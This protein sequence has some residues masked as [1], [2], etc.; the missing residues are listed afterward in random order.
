ML[1]NFVVNY[2]QPVPTGF[3]TEKPGPGPAP[4]PVL[5][6][7]SGSRSFKFLISGSG[8]KPGSE[9]FGPV[10]AQCSPLESSYGDMVFFFTW[11]YSHVFIFLPMFDIV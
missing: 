2:E 3:L 11:F 9:Q 8:S 7:R 10:R 4:E 1:Y 6:I 5:S